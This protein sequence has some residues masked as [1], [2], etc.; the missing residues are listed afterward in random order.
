MEKQN[1]KNQGLEPRE[2]WNDKEDSS[3]GFLNVQQIAN[4]LGIKAST[5]YSLVEQKK[6]PHYRIGR[7]I[8]FIG[9]EIDEWMNLQKEPAV[10]TKVEAK[11][12]L[13]SIEKKSDLD[14]DRIVKKVVEQPKKKGYNFLQEKP[15]RIKDLRKE[16]EDGII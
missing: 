10:D 9:S 14:V 3:P 11:K 1:E 12:V 16:V 13:R 15:G 7:Q 2:K 6:V 8:R 5:V 4:Y